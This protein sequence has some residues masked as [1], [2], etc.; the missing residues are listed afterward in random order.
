MPARNRA[1][2]VLAAM[3]RDGVDVTGGG[4]VIV[5]PTC[6]ATAAQSSANS[7][8]TSSQLPPGLALAVY[9]RHRVAVAAVIGL[10]L[11]A[12]R[13]LH[14]S[15]AWAAPTEIPAVA[16]EAQQKIFEVLNARYQLSMQAVECTHC[17]AEHAEFASEFCD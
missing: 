3:A 12:T 15:R 17:E 1:L 14:C 10:R 16:E 8:A 5:S 6:A 4:G 7:A 11:P 9:V 13:E 2:R